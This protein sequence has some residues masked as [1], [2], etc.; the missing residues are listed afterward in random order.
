MHPCFSM[1]MP[2]LHAFSY[3]GNLYPSTIYLMVTNFM[4]QI[5]YFLLWVLVL[6]YKFLCMLNKF[7]SLFR[8]SCTQFNY[9]MTRGGLRSAQ[10]KQ[11][12]IWSP[13]KYIMISSSLNLICSNWLTLML[14]KQN[15]NRKKRRIFEEEE[16][17]L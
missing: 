5:Y 17:E 9:F 3:L 16:K 4:S 11:G 12:L 2:V 6:Y 8:Y 14:K 7:S 1:R 15:S 13:F 10:P